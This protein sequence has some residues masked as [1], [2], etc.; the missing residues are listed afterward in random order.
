MGGFSSEL[1]K[2]DEA[3]RTLAAYV[4]RMRRQTGS[5]AAPEHR[6]LH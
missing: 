6:T 1:R 2:L 4:A 5:R 3:L